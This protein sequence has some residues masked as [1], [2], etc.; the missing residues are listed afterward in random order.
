M[1]FSPPA[2][3]RFDDGLVLA[4]SLQELQRLADSVAVV[5]GAADSVEA[6]KAVLNKIRGL[7]QRISAP[8]VVALFGGTGVGK[9]T[10][11]NALAGC[12]ASR[13]G[14]ERPT[15]IQPVAVVSSQAVLESAP[16]LA[17]EI[18]RAARVEI[19][20]RLLL[21]EVILVD[22]PDPDSSEDDA[23]E[24]TT[25]RLRRMLPWCDVLLVVGTQQK[26]RNHRVLEELAAA[27]R[28]AAVRWVQTHAD[29]E[30]DIRDDWKT[31]IPERDRDQPI[32]WI[33]ARDAAKRSFRDDPPI[34]EFAALVE[35]L[36]EQFSRREA[37]RI[38]RDN[39]DSLM[40]QV[41]ETLHAVVAPRH[42]ALRRFLEELDAERRRLAECVA[43]SM[44]EEL[45]SSRQAWEMR[46]LEEA[47]RRWGFSPFCLVLQGYHQIGWLVSS[48]MLA[49]VRG[50]G[51]LALWGA[52]EGARQ[53]VR[54][55]Q[56]HLADGA[57]ARAVDWGWD[58]TELR[59]SAMKL[60]GFARDG[61]LT[62]PTPPPGELDAQLA[63]AGEVFLGETSQRLQTLVSEQ[64]RRRSEGWHRWFFETALAAAAALVLARWG[65]NFFVDSWILPMFGYQGKPLFGVD[66]FLHAA[67]WMATCSGALLGLF[68]Y[69]LQRGL[70]EELERL[71]RAWKPEETSSRFF[72][73]WEAQARTL[74]SA[75]AE[76][77]RL[78]RQSL[79]PS[80]GDSPSASSAKPP[81]AAA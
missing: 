6:S 67:L 14:R 22:L 73:D 20:A 8:L 17:E 58:E 15:T 18:S 7:V 55:T 35:D 25:G 39:L 75:D 65:Y 68:L 40:Q 24:H 21:P 53:L 46:L 78:Q 37:V 51:G 79:R 32:Y 66:F 61:G 31:Q 29:V 64:G 60:Q 49:R 3:P 80:P 1:S 36:R 56:E 43:K 52:Y 76:L 63:E 71:L 30:E 42:A 19:A 28:G 41:V 38:R 50:P 10:L 59:Q 54:R 77:T 62:L 69:L 26:Y 47:I 33:D 57:T 23:E 4:R 72:A 9:S 12:E 45:L 27:R 5:E 70:Q 11:C 13:S 44:R 34:G 2:A 74:L 16:D 81:R 48:T